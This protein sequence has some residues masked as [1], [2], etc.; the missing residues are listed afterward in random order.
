MNKQMDKLK[1]KTYNNKRILIF[2]F[3]LFFIGIIAGSLF[4]TIISKQDQNLVRSYIEEFINKIDKNSLN[5]LDVLKN[6]MFS[7]ILFIL[8]V[9][10]LGISIIGIPINIFM[11]FS[12]AFT[13]GFSISALILEYKF[14]GILF[15]IFYIFPHHI[16]N[17]L[18]YTLIVMYSIKVSYRLINGILKKKSINFKPLINKYLKVLCICIGVIIITSLYECFIV[19]FILKR[20]I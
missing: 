2:L 6:T 14:K 5:Y 15:S 7:N 9:F 8:I 11:Y 18:A 1:S 4:I 19:P 12:K 13:L 20:L 17:I 16:I 10:I 3:V